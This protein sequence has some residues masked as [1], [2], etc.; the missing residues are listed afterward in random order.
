MASSPDVGIYMTT[1]DGALMSANDGFARMIGYESAQDLLTSRR[2]T[3]GLHMSWEKREEIITK[4][5]K[6]G[7]A[8]GEV[9]MISINSLV[10]RLRISC[11]TIED[12]TF[13][14]IVTDVTELIDAHTKLEMIIGATVRSI[15]T[16][17]EIRDPYTHGHM[18]NVATMSRAIAVEMGLK[19]SE[20]ECLYYAS[21][22]HDIG[23]IYVPAELLVK[24]TKLSAKEFE[25]IKEHSF[26][27]AKIV[28]SIPFMCDSSV[29]DIIL[30]HHERLDGS[31]YPNGLVGEQI[32]FE[33]KIIAVADAMDAMVNH[34]PYRAAML[35]EH[36]I[37]I[38]RKE[39]DQ[40]K[41]DGEMVEAAHKLFSNGTFEGACLLA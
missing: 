37:G 22:L 3:R 21:I 23:K 11:T 40:G 2:S 28:S 15:S 8:A 30:A 7:H 10:V 36:A 6:S 17:A 34:R 35:P 33:S 27:G 4:A 32:P 38:L 16:M 41:I 5:T 39:A 13:V 1:R 9:D 31:G 12:D 29:P 20:L 24:P 18:V 19:S 14:V 25:I 26:Q